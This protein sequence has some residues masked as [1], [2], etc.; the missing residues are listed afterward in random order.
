MVAEVLK[1]EEITRERAAFSQSWACQECGN[2][3]AEGDVRYFVKKDNQ[4]TIAVCEQ[5][6]E[7]L[8]R[9]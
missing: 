1:R 7:I 9:N 8:T 6:K 3:P 4:D 5:C 2:E